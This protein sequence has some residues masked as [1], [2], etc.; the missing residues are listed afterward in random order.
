MA[1]V[2]FKAVSEGNLHALNE[3]LHDINPAEIEVK[4]ESGSTPLIAAV[5]SGHVDVIL[6]LLSK[7]MSLANTTGA[8]SSHGSP[9]QYATDQAILDLLVQAKNKSLPNVIP[10]ADQTYPHDGSD[11]SQKAYYPPPPPEAYPYY[12]TINP[13]LPTVP[14]GGAFYPPPPPQAMG[15]SH[16]PGGSNNLPPP[17]IARFIPCRYFPACRYGPSCIFAHP[18]QGYYPSGAPP[19]AQYPPYD[20]MSAP[21]Y[22]SNYYPPPNFQ[23]PNGPHPMAPLSPP[24]G[25]PPHLVHARSASEVVSPIQGPF[26]PNGVPPPVPYGPMSPTAY[27]PPAPMPVPLS[28][29]PLPP[30]QHQ[31]QLPPP[32][33]QS[34]NFSPSPATPFNVQQEGLAMYPPPP[35]QQPSMPNGNVSFSPEADGAPKPPQPVAEGFTNGVP[36]PH[37][38]GLHAR[39]SG[40]RTSFGKPKPPCL[41]FP[42]GRCKN[43][44]GCRFPHVMPDGLVPASTHHA[45]YFGGRAGG[46]RQPRGQ[47][48]PN[49]NL[50]GGL[51]EKLNNLNIRDESQTL[52]QQPQQNGPNGVEAG[53]K[54]PNGVNDVAHPNINGPGIGVGNRTR[55]PQGGKHHHPHSH[56]GFNNHFNQYSGKSQKPAV[57]APAKQ[58]VP[59]ADDFPVLVGTITPPSK[60]PLTA[61]G[62]TAAQVLQAPAPAKKDN[63]AVVNGFSKEPSS[64]RGT[65][66]DHPRSPAT[67]T[68]PNG[69]VNKSAPSEPAVNKLSI[70]FA[71]VAATSASPSAGPDPSKEVS[72]S[73]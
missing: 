34:P 12:P 40:R 46:P 47:V 15:E 37:R 64:T 50:S 38:E 69:V 58:R 72:V 27:P 41:F 23:Q 54:P 44:D 73:A 60:S 2:L 61:N 59:S 29:P 13:S 9:E 30:L 53:A 10:A 42:T 24:P 26:N 17:E 68:K 52:L 31:P 21:P 43:G 55:F 14:D 6:A 36:A 4:D 18:P 8:D 66:P 57:Q 65:T 3:I 39:R 49:G 62:P 20:P 45:P 33:P 32:G 35:P 63:A 1:H 11:D 16:S 5:K 28:I 25:P 48:Y 56:H 22:S 51:E 67:S 71:A 70:S 19:P 7:G